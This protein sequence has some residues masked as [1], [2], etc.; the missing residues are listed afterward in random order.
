MST[1]PN[2]DV[3]ALL[4]AKSLRPS[5]DYFL[6]P[7]PH[8]GPL[9]IFYYVWLIR[10]EGRTILVDCGF[11]AE[12]AVTRKR[13]FL[14]CPTE[15][16]AALG[17]AA[18]EIDTVVLTHLHYDHAG[19]I[20]LFP[21][22]EFVVQDEEMRFA[23]GRY[24]RYPPVRAPF[25]AEDVVSLV[26]R[27]YESRVRFVAGDQEL[28]PGIDLHL[29]GGHT[30]GLQAVSVSTKRGRVVLASDA[31]HFFENMTLENPFPIVADIPRMMAGHETLQRLA[32]T[33]D[34]LIPGHDPKVMDLYPAIAADPMTV[35]L[36]AIP[37]G[38]V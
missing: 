14:R 7:D 33:S 12:R 38:G 27:N 1:A 22:A 3:Y 15:G 16:L 2:Y 37:S 34:H 25:E 36:T 21:K 20:D 24:M 17:V 30:Y 10:G 35:D 32:P 31:A 9:P 29:I 18:S 28:A 5:R 23:T 26:R 8:D 6:F 11:S 19:N 4:Y 13:D